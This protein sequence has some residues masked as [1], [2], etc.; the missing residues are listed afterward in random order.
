MMGKLLKYDFKSMLRSFVPLWIAVLVVSVVNRFVIRIPDSENLQA[1]AG[2]I[3][4]MSMLLYVILLI[5]INVIGIVLVIQRF[6]NGLLRDEGYLMFTLP[7]ET[8]KHVCTK[9]IAATAI[10]F[11]NAL[12][13]MISVMVMAANRE[14]FELIRLGMDKLS[15]VGMNPP[16]LVFFVVVVAILTAIKTV[17]II[18]ASMAMGHLANKHRVGASVG[19]FIVLNVAITMI[20]STFML[21]LSSIQGGEWLSNFM[22]GLLE[23]LTNTGVSWLAFAAISLLNILQIVAF[24]IITERI[25][26][27]RLNL[28]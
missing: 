19:A 25:L 7:A 16:L 11:V 14:F 6:Y 22:S 12:V 13:S 5:G 27:K 28:D 21:V 18:Y 4:S 15:A 24:Y 20:A 26:A 2:I 17:Y 9:G 23:G 8:W 10:M 1:I 3:T